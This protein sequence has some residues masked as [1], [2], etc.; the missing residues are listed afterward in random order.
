M[1]IKESHRAIVVFPCVRETVIQV[2]SHLEALDLHQTRQIHNLHQH[3]EHVGIPV[4][5][6]CQEQ[7]AGKRIQLILESVIA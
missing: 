2:V 4:I 1:R 3:Q 7:R 5:V 6:R